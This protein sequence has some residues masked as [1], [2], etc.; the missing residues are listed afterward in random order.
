[1]QRVIYH[2]ILVSLI[3]LT[4]ITGCKNKKAETPATTNAPYSD[5]TSQA[6]VT[7]APDQQLEDGLRDATKDYPGVTATATNGE[8]TLTGK[9]KRDRLPNLMQSIHALQPKKVNNNLTIEP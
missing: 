7:I 4:G 2:F 8:V 6:P 9:I 1:M 3:A 5:T